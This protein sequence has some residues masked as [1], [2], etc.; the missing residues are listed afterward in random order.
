MWSTVD[1]DGNMFVFDEYYEQG[2]VSTHAKAVHTLNFQHGRLPNYYVGD[3]SIR[4]REPLQ[5]SSVLEEY[6]TFGIYIGLANNDVSAGYSRVR[7]RLAGLN[8]RK[9][10]ITR[11]CTHLLY[12][13][14]RLH[15]DTFASKRLSTTNNAKETQK[16]KDDHACDSLRYMVMSRPELYD[17]GKFIPEEPGD[18][19]RDYTHGEPVVS[20]MRQYITSQR[21]H[22]DEHMGANY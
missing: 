16:K 7:A 19:P 5:G 9:L 12:E 11:N 8:N 13:I 21:Q 22:Y 4:N 3:P 18:L 14:N 1:G 2:I 15:Y 10:Y 6:S 20:V 17:D